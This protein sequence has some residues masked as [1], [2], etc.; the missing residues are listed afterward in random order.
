MYNFDFL[1]Y[2]HI[3]KIYNNCYY[4]YVVNYSQSINP[5]LNTPFV[6]IYFFF[7]AKYEYYIPEQK[8]QGTIFSWKL[9]PPKA[10]KT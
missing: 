7:F 1:F 8:Y 6:F 2:S 10:S 4:E 9:T 3:I 5:L